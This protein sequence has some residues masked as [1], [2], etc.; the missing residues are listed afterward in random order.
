[1]STLRLPALARASLRGE[2]HRV[3]LAILPVAASALLSAADLRPVAIRSC[4]PFK[5]TAN[6]EKG[7]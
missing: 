7:R 3:T 1:M 6:I 5:T 4:R 2:N